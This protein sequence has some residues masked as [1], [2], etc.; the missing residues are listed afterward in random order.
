MTIENIYVIKAHALEGGI[1]AGKHIFARTPLT[2]RT[3]PHIIACL[4]GN[5]EF[6]AIGVEI[7]FVKFTKSHFSRTGRRT[8]VIGKVKMRDAKIEGTTGNGASIFN[9]VASAEVVPPTKRDRRQLESA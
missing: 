7:L 9:I 3:R 8:V 4:G 1:E 6:I 2:I 5:D